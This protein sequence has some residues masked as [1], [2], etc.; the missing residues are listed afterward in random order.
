MWRRRLRGGAVN[1][2]RSA[3]AWQ[4]GS[5]GAVMMAQWACRG[6]A[7]IAYSAR[8]RPV[9][10]P[11]LH[12][13]PR[14][15]SAI[16]Q[17]DRPV[18]HPASAWD[19]HA[20]RVPGSGGLCAACGARQR[21]PRAPAGQV[22][23]A[24]RAGAAPAAGSGALAVALAALPHP[25]PHVPLTRSQACSVQRCQEA[26]QQPP[27][28]PQASRGEGAHRCESSRFVAAL[29]CSPAPVRRPPSDCASQPSAPPR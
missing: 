22:G 11:L 6:T 8:W 27:S 10:A 23:W 17:S 2:M 5:C 18:V 14:L 4:A 25:P 12:P 24:E 19:H 9:A 3:C 26:Q 20:G 1:C 29:A 7:G 16:R 21:R 28:S 13:I 15:P